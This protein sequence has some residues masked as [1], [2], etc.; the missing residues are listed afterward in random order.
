MGPRGGGLCGGRRRH[1]VRPRHAGDVLPALG[2]LRGSREVRALRAGAGQPHRVDGQ[3]REPARAGS[4]R[5]G[6]TAGP[7]NAGSPA[8]PLGPAGPDDG[9][10]EF[11]SFA[12][13]PLPELS[14]EKVLFL[15]DIFPTGYMGAEMC[16]I[17]PGDVVAIWGA[18]PV[19]QLAA[20]SARMLGAQ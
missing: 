9:P 3:H 4:L 15:S 14:D 7:G 2:A 6:E 20:A 12:P 16:D 13:A 17:Q 18:G 19:G 5:T 1:P 11:M 10:A 8:Q